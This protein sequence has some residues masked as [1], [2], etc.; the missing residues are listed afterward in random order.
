[1]VSFCRLLPQLQISSLP[2]S[3][4][5]VICSCAA[6]GDIGRCGY[7]DAL[8]PRT[9]KSTTFCAKILRSD[10][11]MMELRTLFFIVFDKR[12][13][14]LGHDDCPCAFVDNRS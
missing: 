5:F 2:L 9:C 14:T 13:A 8:M 4:G 7:A 1:M 11:I 6:D 12:G 10:G 3:M